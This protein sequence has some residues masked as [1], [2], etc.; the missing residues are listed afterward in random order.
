MIKDIEGT[1]TFIHAKCDQIFCVTKSTSLFHSLVFGGPTTGVS[2]KCH[3]NMCSS[4]C[5]N[6]GRGPQDTT[7]DMSDTHTHRDEMMEF[8]TGKEWVGGR[9]IPSTK[10]TYPTYR[11]WGSSTVPIL[12]IGDHSHEGLGEVSIFCWGVKKRPLFIFRT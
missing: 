8:S 10:Q 2:R 3:G 9:Y 1:N 11:T 7:D 12:V 4:V 5:W 6:F